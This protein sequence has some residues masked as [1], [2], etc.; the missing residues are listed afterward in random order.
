MNKLKHLCTMLLAV[1]LCVN[2]A[3][4]GSDEVEPTTTPIPEGVNWGWTM[5]AKTKLT[6]ATTKKGITIICSLYDFNTTKPVPMESITAKYDETK[7]SVV[8]I[9]SPGGNTVL[10]N[11]KQVCKTQ[12]ELTY[13]IEGKTYA[14]VMPVEVL[15]DPN[16]P[17]Y[18]N[19]ITDD[20]DE[21]IFCWKE[22]TEKGYWIWEEMHYHFNGFSDDAET[23]SYDY[24]CKG[25]DPKYEEFYKENHSTYFEDEYE[26]T[27]GSVRQIME[28]LLEGHEMIGIR[29]IL[30]PGSVELLKDK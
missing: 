28:M 21:L 11:G 19:G 14:Y 12:I 2:F 17:L 22:N 13:V 5:D 24:V 8:T 7:V 25:T 20:G 27:K 6:T 3:S 4:C 30:W 18:P 23:I 26:K 1:A 10:V 9:C 29:D 16:E 15:P